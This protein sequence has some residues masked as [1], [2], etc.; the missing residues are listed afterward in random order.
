VIGHEGHHYP[1]VWPGCPRS[2]DPCF[3]P[4]EDGWVRL[5]SGHLCPDHRDTGHTP[6]RFGCVQWWREH[7]RSVVN[8]RGE[9]ARLID[10]HAYDT[11]DE[12]AAAIQRAG[13]VRIT[14]D[15]AAV[16]RMAYAMAREHWSQTHADGQEW[17]ERE[18]W[19]VPSLVYM[20]QARAALAVLTNPDTKE[21]Q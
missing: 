5:F 13:Y 9:L 17:S 16:E 11:G 7:V 1:C 20:A 2:Y 8:Q 3:G 21:I 18:D 6:Q 12:I 10:R 4:A 14:A 15:P 19:G